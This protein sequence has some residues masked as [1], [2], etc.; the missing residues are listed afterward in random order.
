MWRD[1]FLENRAH[2]LPLLRGLEGRVAALRAAIES[3]DGPA[4]E[5]VLASG[6]AARERLMKGG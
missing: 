1:I 6:R 5:A 2:L 4:L 3:G